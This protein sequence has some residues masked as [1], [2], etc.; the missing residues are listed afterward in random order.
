MIQGPRSWSPPLCRLVLWN[1]VLEPSIDIRDIHICNFRLRVLPSCLCS[2]IRL[3]EK[4]SWRGQSSCAWLITTEQ[5][6]NCCRVRIASDLKPDRQRWD[7]HKSNLPATS[8]K[9]GP[10]LISR[11]SSQVSSSNFPALETLQV[12][13]RTSQWICG[14]AICKYVYPL[15]TFN[16]ASSNL[17][18][19]LIYI[20]T[21]TVEAGHLWQWWSNKRSMHECIPVYCMVDTVHVQAILLQQ[22]PRWWN[23]KDLSC[24]LHEWHCLH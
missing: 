6:C 10:V 23:Q 17:V 4:P 16:S 13:D 8:Q 2:S 14:Q 12:T 1:R 22:C 21:S 19:D 9:I 3:Q 11:C 5:W 7:L 20:H 18:M 24:V 15:L